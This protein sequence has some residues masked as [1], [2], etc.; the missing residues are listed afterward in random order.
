MIWTAQDVEAQRDGPYGGGPIPDV[1][2]LP[3]IGEAELP[4]GF[5]LLTAVAP[6]RGTKAAMIAAAYGLRGVREQPMGSN[7]A[8]PVTTWYGLGNVSWCDETV[9]FE[10]DQSGN[11]AAIGGR[12]AFCPAH[13]RWFL[14]Q[15]QWDYGAG[16]IEEG[17]VVF[18]RWDRAR[19]LD[20]EHVGLVVHKYADGTFLSAEGNHDDRFEI[21]HRD[22][23]YVAGRG[24]PKYN[25]QEDTLKTVVDLGAHQPQTIK[26][27]ERRSLSYE[28]EYADQDKVHTDAAKG[29]RYPSVFVKGGDAPYGVTAEVILDHPPAGDV[30][31]SIASYAR[32][33]DTFERDIRGKDLV[34][35]RDVLHS[36][37]RMSD[38][39]KYR[40]DIENKSARDVI[41]KEA[42]LF[43]AH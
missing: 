6:P 2:V 5:D 28:L 11:A 19:S 12:F 4:A 26:A 3:G 29:T 38:Q 32:D 27:G 33:A 30:V 42:Y 25:P 7:H 20:A 31:L 34:T 23:T 41:V 37:I 43:I 17:D 22:G 1:P 8:P 10:G 36:N 18:Y 24:R 15:G 35:E 40:V 14:L 21:V 13:T 39:H 9:S 16:D